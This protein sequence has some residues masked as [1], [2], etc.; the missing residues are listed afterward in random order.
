[1]IELIESKEVDDLVEQFSLAVELRVLLDVKEE[2]RITS[3]D[4]SQMSDRVIELGMY[5]YCGTGDTDALMSLID[6]RING[7]KTAIR[8]SKILRPYIYSTLIT[9]DEVIAEKL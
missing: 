8:E 3:M 2:F 5:A 9:V 1:M 6:Q 4:H 7:L